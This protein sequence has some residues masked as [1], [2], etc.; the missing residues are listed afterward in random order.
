MRRA[1]LAPRDRRALRVLLVV[2]AIAGCWMW[3]IRPSLARRALL[4]DRVSAERALLEREQAAL[5]QN[6]ADRTASTDS[7]VRQVSARLLDGRD[8]VVA[9][10]SLAAYLTTVAAAHDVWLQ[11]VDTRPVTTG[12]AELR[13]VRAG[14]RAEGDVAGVLTFLDALE[15]G[16]PAVRLE[17][18]DLAAGTAGD[19]DGTAPLTINATVL[20]WAA[21]STVA[22]SQPDDSAR[23]PRW[24]L[25]SSSPIASLV[26]RVAS[27][28][29]F[30]PTRQAPAVR[31]RVGAR[32][33]ATG[34]T[35]DIT[36]APPPTGDALPEVL[37]T[38]VDAKGGGFAMVALDG[39]PALVVRAGDVVGPF[40]VQSI[41]RARVLFR[42]AK[43]VRH[44]VDATASPDG[45]VP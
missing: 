25:A 27:R 23:R 1:T 12:N 35:P 6:G 24:A 28:D 18:L 14:L 31:Y 8:A 3:I 45:A 41:D 17:Q 11:Q 44:I 7:L 32:G 20:A 16:G 33:D 30:S 37:G 43:G 15:N 22:A 13:E 9:T 21:A 34:L 39:G 2:V 42:D 40:T 26:E 29:P 36:A 5:A 10:S 4:L 38:A 19:E